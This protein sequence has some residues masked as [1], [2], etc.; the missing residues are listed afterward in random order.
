MPNN[1]Y[2]IVQW[3]TGNVGKS[4]VQAI[5]ANPNYELVG[6]FAWSDDKVGRDAGELVGIEPL[7]V[8]ATNNVD[9]LLALKPD[10]V[11]YNPM[12]INVDELVRI[13]SAGVNV[14][15][16]ASFI[17]GHNLGDDRAR[18]E[19]ACAKGGSTL[20]GSG[21]SPGFAEL[22]AIVAANACDRIDKITIAES[23][24]TTLYDSPETE[25]PV[26]FG[27]AVDDPKLQPMAAKGTAVFAEA[28]RLVADAIGVDL[29][30]I[31]CVA[32]YAETTE[33][34]PMASWT[35]PSGHVAGVY[36]S[37]QGIV[38]GN[39]VID[40]NVRWKK[41]QTL[42]PDWKLDG[43]GWKI[44]IDGRPTVNMQVGFL[45]PQDMIE[46]AKTIEDFFVLGHIMT[47]MPPIHAIP[48]VVAAAPGIA[49]YKDLPLTLPRAAVPAV[50][51]RKQAAAG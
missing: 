11:V 8:S 13:L 45:P 27:I 16:S 21:V 50:Y 18:L 26:G 42:K 43:D 23:A 20:F 47:A 39:T 4:S 7:G 5:A 29:D 19:E 34:L 33:D 35:I 2:R 10:C 17:T 37:W 6:L 32:E 9:S 44:T 24:D 15:A 51:G 41:G 22:L 28:V 31:T 36:A 25:R 46:S 30:D 40:I 14:V 1:P 3:T 49:T 48:A 12:W 38:N